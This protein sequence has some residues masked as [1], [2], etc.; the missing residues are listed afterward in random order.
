[1]AE[2]GFIELE[3]GDSN[4][5]TPSAD[6]VRI[7]PEGDALKAKFDDGSVATLG[8][9]YVEDTIVNGVTDKAPSQNAV[10][11]ALAAKMTNPMTTNGD[12][13]T[14]A[15]GVPARVPVGGEGFILRSLS[16]APT[17]E[18]ENLSQDF[19]DG[20]DGDLNLSGAMTLTQNMYYN[21]L[22]ISPGAVLN[23]GGFQLYAKV[24]DLSNAPAG[25]I[26]RSGNNAANS[27]SNGGAG[28]GASLP[29]ATVA[30]G[31]VGGAGAAGST[32]NGIQGA[33][34]TA[35]SPSNGGSGGQSGLSGAGGTGSSA[36]AASGGLSQNSVH[37]GRF[38]Y[39]FLRGAALVGGGCGGR[40]GNSG[41]GDGV[42]SSRG[43]GG[44]GGGAG[45]IAIYA[46]EIIT[47]GST[48]SGVITAIGG[49]GGKQN[50]APVSGVCGG[51]GGG[52]GGG[53]GFVYLAY[54]KRTGP[55]VSNLISASG[56][57]GGD[58]SPG[59][60]GAFGGNGGGGGAGGHIQTYNVTTGEGTHVV[61]PAGALGS[62][63]T[64][65]A[66]GVGGQGGACNLSL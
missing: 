3:E 28:G 25:S 60:G 46:G 50:N 32:G 29:A 8:A 48:A 16:G 39:Q 4:P 42:N 30:G 6:R 20:S 31:T 11:D 35:S 5:A 63:G 66:G 26:T 17:W 15:A 62:A 19:G 43:G 58:G 41:G 38:E 13:I 55:A 64:D 54:I 61:G 45:V 1:M 59:L 37:F 56:G 49:T 40:G 36:A 34:G 21:V 14:Q 2:S 57:T 10:F 51:A 22:T 53:G 18:E 12:L 65:P 9:N 33:A 23:T 7:Y 44:G 52:G 47:S 24:L 27:S